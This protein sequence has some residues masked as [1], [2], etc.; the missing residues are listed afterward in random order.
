MSDTIQLVP[1]VPVVSRIAPVRPDQHIE[2]AA[3]TKSDNRTTD[4]GKGGD[5][6]AEQPNRQLT[7]SRNDTLGTFVYRSIDEDSGD[8]VWQY[9]NEAR[10]RMSEHLQQ[11]EEK[12]AR[13]QV[14]EKA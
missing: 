9:P 3:E 10:L 6:N 4:N 14:D 13:H 8:V 7:I 1:S 12:N 11:L 2:P 5:S